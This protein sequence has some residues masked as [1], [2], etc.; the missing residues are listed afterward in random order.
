MTIPIFIGSG[1]ADGSTHLYY[2]GRIDEFRFSDTARYTT[3][4]SGDL[5]TAPFVSDADTLL[6]IHADPQ[7]VSGDGG[8]GLYNIPTFG[9]DAHVAVGTTAD[10]KFG[11]G[12]YYLD[13]TDDYISFPDSPSWYFGT[14][15]FT[16]DL[17]VYPQATGEQQMI[18]QAVDGN[19]RWNY[20]IS[21][22][23]QM[24]W[25]MEL[26]G[27]LL[28]DFRETWA[29][30]LNTWHHAAIVRSGTSWYMF[31]NG[32]QLGSTTTDADAVPDVA[33]DLKYG[34]Y[35]AAAHQEFTGGMDEVRVSKGDAR[36]TTNFT[37]PTVAYSVEVDETNSQVIINYVKKF[38]EREDGNGYDR[39][40]EN[41]TTS[42]SIA[43]IKTMEEWK[44]EED[45]IRYSIN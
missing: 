26:G 41:C 4:F 2:N 1:T 35:I 37:P 40:T 32:T 16:I 22:S 30:T 24:M 31:G 14:G 39:C 27:S 10:A 38:I 21:S 5:P 7:D 44:N 3:D 33:S 6:L 18:C 17:W 23:N 42:Y 45:L 11:E 8:K 28:L 29:P 12:G 15:D 34:Y 9:D 13:G 36:W 25:H 19:D 20:Q 43:S